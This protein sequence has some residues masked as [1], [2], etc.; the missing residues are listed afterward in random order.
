MILR[1]DNGLHRFD[2]ILFLGSNPRDNSWGKWEMPDPL[3]SGVGM[4]IVPW[5]DSQSCENSEFW[6]EG[7]G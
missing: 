2:S 4:G 7:V 6:W 3:P 5:R 1:D